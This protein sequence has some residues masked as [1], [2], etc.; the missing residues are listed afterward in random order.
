MT[1]KNKSITDFSTLPDL[2]K[3]GLIEWLL[4][5]RTRKEVEVTEIKD[6]S[7]PY[8]NEHRYYQDIH[9]QA[10]YGGMEHYWL[11]VY[12]CTDDVVETLTEE[13]QEEYENVR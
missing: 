6:F 4:K 8:E 3:D 12:N 7:L 1:N 13:N 11:M 10:N 5:G 2:K 9:I